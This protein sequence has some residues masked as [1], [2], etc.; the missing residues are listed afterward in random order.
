MLLL[1]IRAGLTRY[2]SCHKLRDCIENPH[3]D[4][5]DGSQVELTMLRH[6]RTVAIVDDDPSMLKATEALLNAHGF[7]TVAFNSGEEFLARRGATEIDCLLLDVDLG[8]MSGIEL[9]RQ[10]TALGDRLPVIF[11]TGLEGEAPRAQAIIAGCVAY[12]RKP[13]PTGQL[14]EAINRA[15]H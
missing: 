12:M 9:R 5:C 10:L 15:I 3:G 7:S 13:I 6:Q 8:G 2:H 4:A 1:P 11:M 14:V